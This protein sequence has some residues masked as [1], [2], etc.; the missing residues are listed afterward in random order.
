MTMGWEANV[1]MF[2]DLV[3]DHYIPVVEKTRFQ[4][5]GNER[6]FDGRNRRTICGGAANSAR[7]LAALSRGNTWLWGLSG[8]SPWGDFVQVLKRGQAQAASGIQYRGAHNTAA[9]M[10]TI[11]RVVRTDEK[12]VRHR[13]F[14]ID[15]V[16]SVAVTQSQRQDAL[17]HL[18]TELASRT[19]VDAIIINDLDMG[20]IDRELVR[21]IC[22]LSEARNVPVFVDPKRDWAKYRDF[23]VKCATPN[24]S[25]WCYIVDEV[26]NEREWRNAVHRG[27]SL[28][29]MATLCLQYMPRVD[30]HVIKC[31]KDGL[32]VIA[33]SGPNHRQISIIRPQAPS[34]HVLPG[35]LGAGDILIAAMVLEYITAA[36]LEEAHRFIQALEKATSVVSCYLEMDWHQVPSENDIQRFNFTQPQAKVLSHAVPA[37]VLLLPPRREVDLFELSVQGSHLVSI[38]EPY[39]AV[40]TELVSFLKESWEEDNVRS[41]ILTGRGG[42]GKSEISKILKR[43]LAEC[44]VDVADNGAELVKKWANVASAKIGVNK[45]CRPS[46]TA[47][48]LLLVIDE[49][50]STA[51]HLITG[52]NGKMLLQ[53]LGRNKPTIRFLFID[54]D[55]SR[56]ATEISQSQFRS[57]CN[58]FELPSLASRPHDIPYIFAKFC[59]SQV[60]KQAPKDIKISEK[61][62]L[63]VIVWVLQTPEIDQSTRKID[64][65]AKVVVK[66]A[67]QSAGKSN[68]TLELSAR[69]LPKWIDADGTGAKNRSF[70]V[71]TWN[72]SESSSLVKQPSRRRMPS[73]RSKPKK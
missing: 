38:D 44:K 17:G 6:G 11:T 64:D 50:F 16:E 71:F 20:A 56:H 9:Q 72:D 39:K 7:L 30:C 1:F 12:G 34:D 24:L 8:Y 26:L 70:Y 59:F 22:E 52:E 62:L 37:A 23:R 35:Q 33:P 53:E 63:A 13:E 73:R 31:D 32:V 5:S 14:R 58:L 61:V 18:A 51:R 42:V 68:R 36:H 21:G 46:K 55:Y 29:K 43:E 19:G 69:H 4:P 66:S 2:G 45:S 3:L 47:K 40:I 25:E 49:A 57:R 28:E 48:G 41:A 65:L 60:S 15:D 10:N 67:S 54:A 27:Q